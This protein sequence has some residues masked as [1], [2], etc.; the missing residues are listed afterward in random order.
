M[1]KPE[2]YAQFDR[3]FRNVSAYAVSIHGKQVGR[4]AFKH[5]ESRVDCYAQVWGAAMVK[6]SAGGGGYDKMS[7]AAEAAFAKLAADEKDPFA[8]CHAGSWKKALGAES[9]DGERWT[10][11]LEAAG[12]TVQ[13][14][15][16]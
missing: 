3:A 15:F 11:R 12:Y 14:V 8:F 1:T 13:H 16:G 4:V 2:T 9:R 6:G 7:A 5:G 10:R